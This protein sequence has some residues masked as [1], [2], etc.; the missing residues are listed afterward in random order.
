MRVSNIERLFNTDSMIHAHRT[1]KGFGPEP[2]SAHYT[3]RERK[4]PV[5]ANNM[6]PTSL[7][8]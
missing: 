8:A 1:R 7:R 6:T 5:M 4:A 3:W 2:F